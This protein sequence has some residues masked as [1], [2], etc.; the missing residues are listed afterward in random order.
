MEKYINSFNI[1]RTPGKQ[2]TIIKL[3]K[4]VVLIIKINQNLNYNFHVHTIFGDLQAGSY[5]AYSRNNKI[6][7]IF[8]LPK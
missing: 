5:I 7:P 1:L 3:S 2:N 6:S 8:G 4:C